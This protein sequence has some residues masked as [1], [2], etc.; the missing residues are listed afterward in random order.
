MAERPT[1]W[2][3]EMAIATHPC[4]ALPVS[5]ERKA[6]ACRSR[7]S[8]PVAILAA[9]MLGLYPIAS[10]AQPASVIEASVYE[11]AGWL[12]AA[13]HDPALD[14]PVYCRQARAYDNGTVLSFTLT[15]TG[16][17]DVGLIG[18]AWPLD[19][20]GPVPTAARLDDVGPV[21]LDGFVD[22]LA[23]LILPLD[24]DP[25]IVEAFRRA[26]VFEIVGEDFG[27]LLFDLSGTAAS[28]TD[29]RRC[30]A[31]YRDVDPARSPDNAQPDGVAG[32]ERADAGPLRVRDLARL[33]AGPEVGDASDDRRQS[34][35][36]LIRTGLAARLTGGTG[37]TIAEAFDGA[38]LL[39]LP[40]VRQPDGGGPPQSTRPQNQPYRIGDGD[41]GF[42][43]GGLYGTPYTIQRPS[44]PYSITTPGT[45]SPYSR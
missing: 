26:Y 44:A 15:T 13:L 28:L 9:A 37:L 25:A 38:A 36:R 41:S 24:N 18:G 34:F 14:R 45:A 7:L 5:R 30:V 20:G 39:P 29:L 16:D 42:G 27:P 4:P 32:E 10:P 19:A 11:N 3:M 12:G 23:A 31:T 2:L 6:G 40:V 43:S 33:Q 17:L 1:I 35:D 21:A 22:D 8:A